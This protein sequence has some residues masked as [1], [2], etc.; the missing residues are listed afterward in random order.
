MLARI[1]ER[2]LEPRDAASLAAFRFLFG[3][4]LS[5]SSLRF[6]SNGWVERFYVRPTFFFKYWGFE[7]V[8]VL[9]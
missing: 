3:A 2:L 1:R 7:W 9:P 4:I 6:L 8:Q 5:L